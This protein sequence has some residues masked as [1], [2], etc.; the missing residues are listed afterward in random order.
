LAPVRSALRGW[1]NRCGVDTTTAQNVL[2]AAGEACANAIEHGHRQARHG[3]IRL[4]ASATADDLQLTITDSGPWKTQQA[5]ADP[6]RGRG[7]GLMRALMNEV[8]I[9]TG[10]GGTVVGLQARINR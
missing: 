6:H 8:T 4:R 1:L 5:A 3:R 2:V 7:L 9:T 10:A